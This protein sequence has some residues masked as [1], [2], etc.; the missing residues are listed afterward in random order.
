M[1]LKA[2]KTITKQVKLESRPGYD[3]E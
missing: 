1:T 3:H 2:L